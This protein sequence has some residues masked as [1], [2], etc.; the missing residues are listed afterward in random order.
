MFFSFL[1]TRNETTF[2]FLLF[3]CFIF[4]TLKITPFHFL[5]K[6][7]S[8]CHFS[9]THL[10][11]SLFPIPEKFLSHRFICFFCFREKTRRIRVYFSQKLVLVET[12]VYGFCFL[13]IS[14]GLTKKN[15]NHS[16]KQKTI[17][18]QKETIILL[19]R[20]TLNIIS[21]NRKY[22]RNPCSKNT[23]F[24]CIFDVTIN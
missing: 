20:F 3:L 10:S 23:S 24:S 9:P 21:I 5:S 13:G 6:F 2:Q 17:G 4:N 8:S 14:F 12:I 11:L 1:L 15:S 7:K 16:N 19:Y 22:L 18:N